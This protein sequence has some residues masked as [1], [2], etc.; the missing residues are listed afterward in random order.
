MNC[1]I[2]F[3]Y[4]HVHTHIPNK[5]LTNPKNTLHQKKK[6]NIT[7]VQFSCSFSLALLFLF[8]KPLLWMTELSLHGSFAAVASVDDLGR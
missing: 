5:M 7:E 8:L 4:E 1:H 6:K 2:P 3:T